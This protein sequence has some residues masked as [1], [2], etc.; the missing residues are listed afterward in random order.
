[1]D[2]TNET[3]RLAMLA[4]AAS[5]NHE[6]GDPIAALIAQVHAETVDLLGGSTALGRKIVT[7]SDALTAITR[8]FPAEVLDALQA[9]GVPQSAIEMVIAPTANPMDDPVAG[10][11]LTCRE[12]D[13]AWRLAGA[14]A[15]ASQ[16]LAGRSTANAWLSRPKPT[17]G[18]MTGY[19]ALQTSVGTGCL[20]GVLYRLDSGSTA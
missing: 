3:Q 11:R 8:G 14:V 2:T 20:K 15:L 1:M 17:L 6:D 5:R 13:A 16:V 7:D 12:S 9:A 18:G 19:E 10:R 4:D